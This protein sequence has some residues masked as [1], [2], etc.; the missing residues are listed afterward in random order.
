MPYIRCMYWNIQNF[1]DQNGYRARQARINFIA[2]A[3]AAY[4]PDVLFIMELKQNAIGNLYLQTLQETLN[5]LPAPLNNWYYDWIKGALLR[6]GVPP[7]PADPFNTAVDTDWD[8]AH[9]EG[10]AVFWNQN[11][12]KFVMQAAPPIRP[13]A[14]A[15]PSPNSQSQ[16]CRMQGAIAF[17]GPPIPFPGVALGGTLAVPGGGTP[18]VVPAGTN[19]PGQGIVGANT[20]TAAGVVL[21]AG[22]QVGAGGITLNAVTWGINPVVVPGGYTLTDALTLPASGTVVLP[23]NALGLAMFG[24]DSAD[25]LVN[26]NRPDRFNGD[27]S[28]TTVNFNPLGGNVWNW[29]EFTGAAAGSA[30]RTGTRRPAY[31]TVKVNRP[32]HATAADQL[33]PIICY[34]AP[35]A[36]PASSGGMQRA[37]FSQPMYQ[38]YDWAGGGNWIN[39]NNALIGG[40]FN[41]VIDNVFYAYDAFTDAFATPSGYGGGANA[42]MA[43][44]NPAPH[45]GTMGD[46]PLNQTIC[47]LTV[48]PGG[49]A[50]YGNAINDFRTQAIDNIFYR[51]LGT[52]VVGMGIDAANTGAI[53]MMSA[54]S[55]GGAPMIGNPIAQC[56]NT[57]NMVNVQTAVYVHNAALALP[58]MV[59]STVTLFEMNA[60]RFSTQPDFNAQNTAARRVAEFVNLFASDHLPVVISFTM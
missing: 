57:P 19:I 16:D 7:L 2:S 60:G 4:Q 52:G 12:A 51:G 6:T 26:P 9:H 11:I 41:V 35:S 30:Q 50:R 1:G 54:C 46:N 45:G 49:P 28:D 55:L 37:A 42:T 58:S 17:G 40:D 24:R 25:P 27:I 32:G 39:C 33:L 53:D 20:P 8:V 3:V 29:I 47:A 13:P 5:T 44:A 18:F 59:D 31:I 23:V 48:G 43:I 14:A 56:L 36:S 34:H 22:T 10:Y 15:G 21:P 38:A